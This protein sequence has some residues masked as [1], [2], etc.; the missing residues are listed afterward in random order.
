[1]CLSSSKTPSIPPPDPK[2]ATTK[3][4][5]EAV[6]KV[7]DSQKIRAAAALG[8]A[9]TIVTSPFGVSGTA[10]TSNKSLLGAY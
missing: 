6:A 9:G 4:T 7:R 1:M 10:Q 5:T 2:P 3:D 8:Q